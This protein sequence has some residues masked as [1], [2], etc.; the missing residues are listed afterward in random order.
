MEIW[1]KVVD[2]ILLVQ[3]RGQWWTFVKTVL[4]IHGT[5]KDGEFLDYLS[6]Y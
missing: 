2:G 6:N 1:W 4:N 5:I 3:D